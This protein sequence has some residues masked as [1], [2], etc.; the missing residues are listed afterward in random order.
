MIK[1]ISKNDYKESLWKNGSGKTQEI[2]IYPLEASIAED[3]FLW[4]ISSAKVSGTSLFS[5]FIGC[6]R[7]LIVW[8]GAGLSINQT[9]LLPSTIFSFSGEEIVKADILKNIPVVDFGIIYKRE[10]IEAKL[11]II[12]LSPTNTKYALKSKTYLFFLAGGDCHIN[13]L[14]LE[15]GDSILIEDEKNIDILISK[16]SILYKIEVDYLTRLIK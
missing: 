5:K 7:H 16:K 6:N 15:I 9:D 11:E 14:K 13:N 10:K 1:L 2:A 3:N 8:Q 4:R 12:N